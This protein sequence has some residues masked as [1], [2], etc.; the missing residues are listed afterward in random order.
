[1]LFRS[2][3]EHQTFDNNDV[4]LAMG[5]TARMSCTCLFVM[6][7][8]Q[9]FCAAWVKASPDVAKFKVDL[10]KKVVEATG[11]LEWGARAHFVDERRGCLLE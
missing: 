5:N 3:T 9:D 6:N 2:E 10:D 11:L 4:E 7:M 8:P 1:M